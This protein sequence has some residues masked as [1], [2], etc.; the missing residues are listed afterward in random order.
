MRI[1]VICEIRGPIK[2]TRMMCF[3][4]E[5]ESHE[6]C[7]SLRSCWPYIAD[8]FI[9]RGYH[10]FHGGCIARSARSL[11]ARR[12]YTSQMAVF[13]KGRQVSLLCKAKA[14]VV[15]TDASLA[16]A[17]IVNR[18]RRRFRF[19]L[20]YRLITERVFLWLPKT[21]LRRWVSGD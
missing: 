15:A 5:H 21:Q 12:V 20:R 11:S 7:K 2:F 9:A 16:S 18:L 19:R 13:V 8:F 4:L 6:S 1:R 3:F 17:L 14:S 10:G